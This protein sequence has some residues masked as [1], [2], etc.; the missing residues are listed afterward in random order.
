ME[1]KTG[2]KEILGCLPQALLGNFAVGALA[3]ILGIA[4]GGP[5]IFIEPNTAI[6]VFCVLLAAYGIITWWS[7][8]TLAKHKL[9]E[10][11]V[12]GGPYRFVRH[13]MYSAV[14]FILNPALGILFRSWW[15]FLATIP[16]YFIWRHYVKI[17]DRHLEEKFS[18]YAEYR[19]QT[20]RL[21]P[22]LRR[23]NKIVFYFL[24]GTAF[25]LGIFIFLNF[26]A[27]YLRW[28]AWEEHGQIVYDKQGGK[29]T[30]FNDT[31]GAYA[32]DY[33]SRGN[34]ILI[35]KIGVSAP[36]VFSQGVSQK[37]L[38]SALDQGVVVYPGSALPGQNGEVFLTGHSSVFPWNK[39]P[40]GQI[41]TLLDKLEAGDTVSL[42]YG[43]RQYDY[44]I[45]GKEI[46]PPNQVK[47]TGNTEPRLT[48]FTCWP[49]GTALKRL[50][51]KGELIK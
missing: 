1:Q 41:F 15:L 33:N 31:N 11:L 44:R 35:G 24:A 27:I 47:I 42:V 6:F 7:I 39:T 23:I 28:A 16:I 22:D 25:F 32:S 37:E 12:T 10:N 38:N 3:L 20:G 8:F 36:L 19:R 48:L 30:R 2:L 49:I 13:P 17:E 50:L 34:S 40:Y 26:S 51:V 4:F 43:N 45:T 9:R 21:F 46:L 5:K 18:Q 14:I 29:K